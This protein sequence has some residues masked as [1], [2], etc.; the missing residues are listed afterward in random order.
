MA[1]KIKRRSVAQRSVQAPHKRKTVVRP[2]P[3]RPPSGLREATLK[4]AWLLPE[5]ESRAEEYDRE[6]DKIIH[7]LQNV[8]PR[9]ISDKV[10]EYLL[11]AHAKDLY[12]H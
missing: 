4:V 6:A 1:K 3:E 10:F 8:L 7:F 11:D 12:S 9:G 2:H 5:D